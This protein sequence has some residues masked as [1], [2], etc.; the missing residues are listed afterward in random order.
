M[1]LREAE[2]AL[3]VSPTSL[4]RRSLSGLPPSSLSCVALLK[5][6]LHSSLMFS[7]IRLNQIIPFVFF[8][9]FQIRRRSFHDLTATTMGLLSALITVRSLLPFSHRDDHLKLTLTLFLL[10]RRRPFSRYG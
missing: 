9:V 2:L 10:G 1:L 5:P 6:R 8:A 4:I 7:L 3:T